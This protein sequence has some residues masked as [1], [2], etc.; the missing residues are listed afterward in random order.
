MTRLRI[1]YVKVGKIR[2]TSHRDVA[3][4]WERAFRQTRFP[5]A[6]SNGFSPRP[7][8]SFGL[9]LPTGHESV[10]EYLDVDVVDGEAPALGGLA[11][12][13]SAGLPSGLDAVAVASIPPGTSSLQE[14]V[15][16]CTWRW[17]VGESFGGAEDSPP[18]AWLEERVSGLRDAST[19]VIS[20]Q[21]KGNEVAEDIRP[22]ILDLRMNEEGWLVADLATRPRSIRPADVLRALGPELEERAV[23]RLHQ[24]ILR[25]DARQEPLDAFPGSVAMGSVGPTDAPHARERANQRR[26]R[27]DHARWRLGAVRA[28]AT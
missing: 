6:Y 8:I 22:A 5:V 17:S 19:A 7:R 20:R 10:A 13:L 4:M 1:R 24:W 2:W 14:E 15:I 28:T 25:D 12:S 11:D 3:R 23:R 9:A 16:S 21:R 18:R 26:D 27:N